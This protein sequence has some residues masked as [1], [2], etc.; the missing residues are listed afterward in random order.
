MAKRKHRLMRMAELPLGSHKVVKVGKRELG[1]FHINGRYHALPNLCPHQLGP[2]C[3]GKVS[4]TTAVDAQNDWQLQ[5][6]KEGEIVACPWHGIEYH[7]PTGQCLPFPE[8]KIRSY[9][10]FEEE[11]WLV[12][13][14]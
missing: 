9:A 4:G 10:V 13:E 3:E 1:V 8:I 6:I 14:I 2:L 12:L 5:W 7:V 11:G